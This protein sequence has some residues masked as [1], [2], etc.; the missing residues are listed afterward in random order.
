[1]GLRKGIE[2]G[3][4][5][6]LWGWYKNLDDWKFLKIYE[7]NPNNEGDRVPTGLHLSTNKASSTEL[8]YI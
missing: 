6:E 5:Q 3:R 8:G 7:D 2:K 4:T 1:M